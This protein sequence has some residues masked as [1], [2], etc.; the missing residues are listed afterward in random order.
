VNIPIIAGSAA[1]VILVVLLVIFVVLKA[2]RRKSTVS[3][4]PELDL[5]VSESLEESLAENLWGTS[6]DGTADNPIGPTV[7]IFMDSVDETGM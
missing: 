6:L 7:N 4:N 1:G 5:A 3:D 2:S